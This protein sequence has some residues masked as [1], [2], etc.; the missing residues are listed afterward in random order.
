ML[1][2][3][4]KLSKFSKNLRKL[5]HFFFKLVEFKVLCE[6]SVTK[7]TEVEPPLNPNITQH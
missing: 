3:T 7:L 6:K 5:I 2:Y 4:V 1:I